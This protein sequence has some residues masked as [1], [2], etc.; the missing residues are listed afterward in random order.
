MI[1]PQPQD[2]D[3]RVLTQDHPW[4]ASGADACATLPQVKPGTSKASL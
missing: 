3:L 2:I 1:D 4:S